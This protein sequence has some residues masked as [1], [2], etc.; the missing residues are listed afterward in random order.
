MSK[1]SINPNFRTEPKDYSKVEF[2]KISSNGLRGN[3][4]KEFR[5]L[6]SENISWESEQIA[7]SHGIYLEYNRA[8]TG[9]EKDW[10]YMIRISIPGG[11]PITAEQ[12]NILDKIADKYTIG[13]QDVHPY[14]RPSLR[15]T[16]R[17]NIQLH[18]VRKKDVVNVIREVAESGFFTINGCGD[19]T[20]NV[21]GC[22]LSYYSKIFNATQWAQK[23]GKYFALPT[24]AFIE[25]FEIDRKYL[26][27]T[28]LEKR[29]IGI[30]QFD[31]GENQLNRKFKIAFSAIHYNKEKGK[32]IPDN[33]VELL[34]NDIGVAPIIEDCDDD[35]KQQKS[36]NID[37]DG[38]YFNDEKN[39]NKPLINKFQVYIGGG[40]GQQAGKPTISTL[41]EP[42]GIFTEDNL[43][44]GLDAILRVHKEWGDR[45]NRH[46]ARLKY[47]M[48]VK[49][50]EWF[51]AQV[52]KIDSSLDFELPIQS[53]DYGSRDLHLGWIKQP[54]SND[55]NNQ[56]RWCFGTFIENGRIIDGSPN[57]NL[58]SMI[59]YLMNKYTDVKLFTTPNQHL[60]FSNITDELKE[61]F[62]E[63]MKTIFGY[64]VL[65]KNNNSKIRSSSSHPYSKLR[66]L[67]G[68]CVGRD[69][70]RLT[71][72]DSE[73][74]EPYLIDELEKKWGS[75]HESIGIT[76]CEKQCYRPATK[77]IGWIGTGFNLYQLT[78]MGT[79]DGRHQGTPLIDPDS[80]EEYLHFVPRK[81]VATVT[82]AL[83]EYYIK[84]CSTIYE[85]CEPGK[86]GYFMRRVGLQEII[87][88]LKSNPM[89]AELMKKSFR[90][91]L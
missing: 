15:I 47:V 41:G 19:N 84:N 82:D 65:C 64:G 87:L 1:G 86:M 50:I 61:Q 22:P 21:V 34:T 78:L 60:L 80:K 8:K 42:F 40:Q 27:K 39:K 51:R 10:M 2:V 5:D 45:Q 20:R 48:K 58:K 75:I 56:R 69:T 59:K 37:V 33:C 53:H 13:P 68:A 26:R 12:W 79:E 35:K 63:D 3:L 85:E 72:T 17:Q 9:T 43:L 29:K 76:G 66:M 49:G 6:K 25:V 30:S 24:S 62:E 81:Y 57:G 14:S 89:T 32:Y 38:N 28:E 83:F 16:T 11:G 90:T 77:T 74:F 71:Y 54:D 88:Y 31:Y 7:K 4:Y 67:S 46:W 18:W 73:K 23:A 44:K 52:R 70:C 36:S 91:S 55:N